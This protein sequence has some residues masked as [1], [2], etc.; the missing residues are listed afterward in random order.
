[1]KTGKKKRK[2]LGVGEMVLYGFST[3][4]H[5]CE[6]EALFYALKTLCCVYWLGFSN[7]GPKPS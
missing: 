4:A 7:S 3:S 5:N 2:E 1:M 6:T